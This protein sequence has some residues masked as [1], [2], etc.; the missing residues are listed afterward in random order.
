[1]LY[2]KK[3]IFDAKTMDLKQIQD[4]CPKFLGS[5]PTSMIIFYI[6]NDMTHNLVIG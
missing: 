5:M 4:F 3:T 6:D 2:A 1:M